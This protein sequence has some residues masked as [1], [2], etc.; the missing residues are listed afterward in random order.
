M[1]VMGASTNWK[2]NNEDYAVQR[3]STILQMYDHAA[4]REAANVPRYSIEG[5]CGMGAALFY[6]LTSLL[7]KKLSW[8]QQEKKTA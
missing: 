8:A 1:A 7:E 6:S 3:L 2:A 5:I 4:E